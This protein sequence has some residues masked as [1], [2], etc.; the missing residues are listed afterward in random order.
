MKKGLIKIAKIIR[1]ALLAIVLL[2]IIFLIGTTIWN[3]A[4]CLQED[5]ILNQ[6]GTKVDANGVNIRTCVTGNGE[7][8]IVLLSGLGTPSPIIDFK[9]LAEKLSTSYRVVTLEYTGYGLSEDANV[10]KSNK[11]IVE[12][13]RETLNQLHIK[14]PY[15]LMPHS[16]SG[17]YCL[18]YMKS[19]PKEV[20]AMIGIDS[21]V[22][23]QG[24]Y[25]EN[26]KISNGLYY[27]VR[28]MDF[29][30]LTRLSNL[31]RAAFLKDMEAGGSYSKKEMKIVT[32][33]YNRKQVTRALLNESR[34]LPENLKSLYDVKYPADKPVL[35]IL[36]DGT[37]KQLKEE[38][39]KLGY[40][41]SWEGLHEEVISNPEIQKITYLE[42]QHYLHWTQANTI[43]DLTEEFLQ[44]DSISNDMD[45][46]QE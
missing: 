33:L 36:S 32:A 39:K 35:F 15:I 25:E 16:I 3:K 38:S 45:V 22:P 29:T 10:D 9:P 28:F 46:V 1:N 14:P 41:A 31:S 43:A 24:K 17:V 12:E 20:E 34:S 37:C 21:S 2:V 5:K 13:I 42:G 7:K 11:A 30:G 8:T 44:K 19:Y 26:E 27:L 18:Q 40:E 23:N 6:V 4:I